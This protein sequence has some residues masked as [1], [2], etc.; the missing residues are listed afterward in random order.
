MG[1]ILDAQ[2]N[3]ARGEAAQRFESTQRLKKVALDAA[4]KMMKEEPYYAQLNANFAAEVKATHVGFVLEETALGYEAV[5]VYKLKNGDFR[6]VKYHGS[7]V[8]D[9]L[10][11]KHEIIFE[12]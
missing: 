2:Q 11:H 1:V 8:T 12:T 6:S 3:S 10:V 4:K 7:G 5:P 9:L